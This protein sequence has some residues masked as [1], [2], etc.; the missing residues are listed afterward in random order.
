MPN[1]PTHIGLAWDAK[2]QM[3]S[4][5]LSNNLGQYLLGSTAPDIRVITKQPRSDYHFVDLDFLSI[6]DG[7]KGLF[8]SF[9]ELSNAKHLIPEQTAFVAGYLSHLVADETWITTMYRNYFSSDHLFDSTVEAKLFDRVAQLGMDKEIKDLIHSLI[10]RID[11]EFKLFDLGPI[12]TENMLSWKSWVIEFLSEGNA[13]SWER[14]R[15]QASRISK[16]NSSHPIHDLSERFIADTN[17]GIQMLFA[18]VPRS[19][20]IGYRSTA[21]RNIVKTVSGYLS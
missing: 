14:I 4:S 10:P 2:H 6:G 5:V 7:E 9:P 12:S 20:I 16:N 8:N 1:L 18:N 21:I 3:Q 17:K 15:N 11:C 13:F 19:A